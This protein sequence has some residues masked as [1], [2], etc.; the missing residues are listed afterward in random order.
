MAILQHISIAAD[1]SAVKL[2]LKGMGL[3]KIIIEARVESPN[4]VNIIIGVRLGASLIE[5]GRGHVNIALAVVIE[6]A[7]GPSEARRTEADIPG[8]ILLITGYPLRVVGKSGE[9]SEGL[10]GDSVDLLGVALG[11][12]DIIQLSLLHVLGSILASQL[13]VWRGYRFRILLFQEVDLHIW[14][15]VRVHGPILQL[16]ACLDHWRFDPSKGV[17]SLDLGSELIVFIV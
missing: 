2:E 7:Q 16:S 13:F 9:V 4:G 5:S 17:E 1:I 12:A 10:I 14:H 6:L 11:P 15:H 3:F 8:H